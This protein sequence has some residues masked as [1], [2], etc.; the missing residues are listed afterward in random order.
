MTSREG[1]PVM[2]HWFG[3]TTL[4]IRAEGV[5]SPSASGRNRSYPIQIVFEGG[6]LNEFERFLDIMHSCEGPVMN[7]VFLC[8]G[9]MIYSQHI[10]METFLKLFHQ[11]RSS[12]LL[13]RFYRDAIAT[14]LNRMA[15]DLVRSEG[16]RDTAAETT[17][18]IAAELS[19]AAPESCRR[20]EETDGG[21][22]LFRPLFRSLPFN[23]RVALILHDIEG[24]DYETIADLTGYPLE[25]VKTQV[26]NARDSLRH[27][28]VELR[29]N[30]PSEH[31]T[32]MN[33]QLHKARVTR[34]YDGDRYIVH[35]H[36]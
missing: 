6:E 31:E 19:G 36:S 3:R 7:F 1:C 35:T 21:A 11:Y 26:A 28:Y 12:I 18:S 16:K 4:P 34:T 9:N 2:R 5:E 8:T 23:A 15:K 25:A 13:E 30:L 14:T 22:V 27:R 24:M 33:F 29:E 10:V 17:G 20:F 32:D